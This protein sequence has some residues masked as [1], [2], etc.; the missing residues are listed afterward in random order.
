MDDARNAD[1]LDLAAVEDDDGVVD[2][3]AAVARAAM[4]VLVVEPGPRRWSLDDV[5]AEV[6]DGVVVEVRLRFRCDDVRSVVLATEAV[7]RGDRAPGALSHRVATALAFEVWRRTGDA[8]GRAPFRAVTDADLFPRGGTSGWRE[9]AVTSAPADAPVRLL[10][11][12]DEAGRATGVVLAGSGVAFEELATLASGLRR[13]DAADV[14][15]LRVE[16]R[17]R[18][19]QRW[20]DAPRTPW[21]PDER[22]A[23]SSDRSR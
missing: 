4:P 20:W 22:A 2:L 10:E 7:A 16:H 9:V 11:A 5:S 18:L 12:V 21:R 6:D 1:R 19:A 13:C 3:E 14:A 8:A 23:A 15:R 17:R